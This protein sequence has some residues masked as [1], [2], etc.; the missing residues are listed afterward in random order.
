MMTFYDFDSLLSNAEELISYK[1]FF[2]LK[3]LLSSFDET[4]QAPL[5]FGWLLSAS[6]L[7]M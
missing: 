3:W 6:L 5:Y 1:L 7:N 4:K 2:I